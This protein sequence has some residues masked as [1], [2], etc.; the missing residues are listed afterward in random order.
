MKITIE[1]PSI[2]EIKSGVRL[3]L[4]PNG[5]IVIEPEIPQTLPAPNIVSSYETLPPPKSKTSKPSKAANKIAPK[6]KFDLETWQ[7]AAL[8]A[9]GPVVRDHTLE[10]EA[11]EH[12]LLTGLKLQPDPY[13]W[14]GFGDLMDAIFPT[15]NRREGNKSSK[16]YDVIGRVILRLVNKNQMDYQKLGEGRGRNANVQYRLHKEE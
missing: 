15:V 6:T 14:Y 8:D 11:V 16:D 12:K 4:R 10:S 5:V 13:K 2:L 7:T 9:E 1:T 3:S